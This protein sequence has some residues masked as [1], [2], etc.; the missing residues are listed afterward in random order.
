MHTTVSSKDANFLAASSLEA[1]G[2]LLII[3][4][5]GLSKGSDEDVASIGEF[6]AADES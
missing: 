6:V 1:H 5:L 3:L 4:P 2:I